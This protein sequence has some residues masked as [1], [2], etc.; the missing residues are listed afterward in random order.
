MRGELGTL[1]VPL[2]VLGLRGYAR[3]AGGLLVALAGCVVGAQLIATA[4]MGAGEAP[5]W[6][7]VVAMGV[8]VLPAVVSGVLFVLSALADRRA[9]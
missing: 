1:G 8:R 6:G 2:A 5:V 4:V 9:S 7:G 3:L